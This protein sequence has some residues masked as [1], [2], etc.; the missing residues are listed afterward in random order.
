MATASLDARPRGEPRNYRADQGF[1]LTLSV[2][3]TVLT[4]AG[5]VQLAARGITDPVGAPLHVHVHALLLVGWLGLFCTQNWLAWHGR[6][7]L[8]RQLGRASLLLVAAIVLANY[9]IT[10]TAIEM[11]RTGA[12]TP[13]GFLALGAADTLGFAGL[14]A[15]AILRR[16]DTQWHRRLIFGATLMLAAAGFNRLLGDLPIQL[17]VVASIGAQLAFVAAIG[18]HDRRTAGALHGATLV[19]A[20]AV[21]LQRSLPLLLPMA[22]LWVN[23][24]TWVIG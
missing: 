15:W 12:F 4:A 11:G 21:V 13:A 23:F 22:P 9:H 5:F 6:L 18:W 16:R 14:F 8:H 1:F 24:A 2:L 17:S 20:L 10:I 19:L 3:L 7:A